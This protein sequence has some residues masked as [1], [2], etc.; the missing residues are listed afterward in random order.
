MHLTCSGGA[1]AEA[2]AVEWRTKIAEGVKA[3]EALRVLKEL[4]RSAH[5]LQQRVRDDLRAQRS[6]ME[7]PREQPA[8]ANAEQEAAP[9]RPAIIASLLELGA[10]RTLVAY[11][12]DQQMNLLDR[13]N[14]CVLWLCKALARAAVAREREEPEKELMRERKK[15]LMRQEELMKCTQQEEESTSLGG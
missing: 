1:D 13:A 12:H 9:G 7:H 6:L 4:Q 11:V 2:D 3:A 8:T 15:E 5:Q 10:P 14:S